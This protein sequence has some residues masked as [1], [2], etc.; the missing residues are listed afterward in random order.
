MILRATSG[1]SYRWYTWYW[2]TPYPTGPRG[3]HF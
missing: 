1:F 2:F 3:A